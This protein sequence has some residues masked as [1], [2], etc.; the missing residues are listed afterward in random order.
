MVKIQNFMK[1]GWLQ[2]TWLRSR[3]EISGHVSTW[4]LTNAVI[5]LTGGDG[6]DSWGVLGFDGNRP[7]RPLRLSVRTTI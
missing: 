4:A 6:G 1:D 7:R 2:L 5:V 3:L